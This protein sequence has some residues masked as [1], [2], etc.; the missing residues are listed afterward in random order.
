[1]RLKANRQHEQ[2]SIN[3]PIKMQEIKQD[4]AKLHNNKSP[5][6]DKMVNELLKYGGP[7]LIGRIEELFNAIFKSETNPNQWRE[8]ILFNTDNGKKDKEKL[9]NK[10]GISL[11]NS[12]SKV[13][14][15]IIVRRVH[16]EI[17]FREAQAG[18]ISNR[19]TIGHIFTL[20][21][22]IQQRLYEKKANLRSI[23]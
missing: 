14:E 16:N 4:I 2:L 9:E 1:M 8:A 19:S 23:Y 18:G 20:K 15:K 5:G 7:V 10:R 13:F 6:S 3:Q 17:C 12:I 21:S 11:S 22:V